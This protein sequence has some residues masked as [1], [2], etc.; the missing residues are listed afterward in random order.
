MQQCR[1]AILA[2]ALH[3]RAAR[4]PGLARCG[5]AI[6]CGWAPDESDAVSGSLQSLRRAPSQLGVSGLYRED[7]RV[8]SLRRGESEDAR[9]C[10]TTPTR[11]GTGCPLA[12]SRERPQPP[13]GS[14]LA[15]SNTNGQPVALVKPIQN[16]WNRSVGANDTRALDDAPHDSRGS[17]APCVNFTVVAGLSDAHGQ[18]RRHSAFDSQP[19]IVVQAWR[20]AG[21]G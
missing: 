2:P 13:C 15:I 19:S 7:A 12:T 8:E 11:I 21:S 20:E 3:G 16:A 1:V 18:A 10:D 14:A 4:D 17:P 6:I 9:D 5:R